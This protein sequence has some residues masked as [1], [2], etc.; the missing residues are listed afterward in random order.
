M[1]FRCKFVL[2]GDYAEVS[3][4]ETVKERILEELLW[5]IIEVDRIEFEHRDYCNQ[6]NGMVR[7]PIVF[8]FHTT[9]YEETTTIFDVYAWVGSMI[10]RYGNNFGVDEI[11]V[12][13]FQVEI[14]ESYRVPQLAA[15][16][17]L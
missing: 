16:R 3:I 1:D 14:P 8:K 4:F 2:A 9:T 10:N 17:E 11:S 15:V 7:V 12:D 13:G 6:L 5:D